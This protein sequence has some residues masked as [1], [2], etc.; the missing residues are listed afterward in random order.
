MEKPWK[1]AYRRKHPE[2]CCCGL[3]KVLER[4]QPE[5]ICVTRE[6]WVW[7]IT[8][9]ERMKGTA[10]SWE[11]D[12]CL[13]WCGSVGLGTVTFTYPTVVLYMHKYETPIS[14]K[15]HP[16]VSGVPG[17]LRVCKWPLANAS[18]NWENKTVESFNV[19]L[20][21]VL[22]IYVNT[23]I[24]GCSE[25]LF[26]QWTLDSGELKAPGADFSAPLGLPWILLLLNLIGNIWL[27]N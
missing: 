8:Q 25:W 3:L 21:F 2:G 20:S 17:Q 14:F 19:L 16:N 6:G 15:L 5:I 13:F 27:R 26:S 12:F 24:N 4:R 9:V 22:A 23:S 1:L 7:L 18:P 10:D 11:M